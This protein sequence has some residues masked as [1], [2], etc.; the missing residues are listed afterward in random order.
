M[1]NGWLILISYRVQAFNILQV[2]IRPYYSILL[3]AAT[4]KTPC[5]GIGI[6]K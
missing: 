1:V 3:L 6:Q 5:F 2:A 4:S